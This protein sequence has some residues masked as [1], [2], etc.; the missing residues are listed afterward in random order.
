VQVVIFWFRLLPQIQFSAMA[1]STRL[2]PLRQ[3]GL[4]TNA[5]AAAMMKSAEHQK[6]VFTVK[7]RKEIPPRMGPGRDLSMFSPQR[8][9]FCPRAL[10]R[11]GLQQH[12]VL[13]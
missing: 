1:L 7:I 2:Q 10:L 8:F 4:G 9:A 12:A 11:L 13:K 6:T 5:L 3:P